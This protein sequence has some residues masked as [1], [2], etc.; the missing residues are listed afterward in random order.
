[1]VV[2]LVYFVYLAAVAI[3][4]PVA[5]VRR[6]CAVGISVLTLASL[7]V[8]GMPHILPLIYLLIGYWLPALLVAHP[9]TALEQYL[10]MVDRGL[11][12]RDGLLSFAQNAP[13]VALE[14]LELAYLFCYAVVPLGFA[15]LL[16]AGFVNEADMF[17]SMVLGASFGCYGMLPWMPTR[18][19]RVLEGPPP[20]ERA[21]VRKLNLYV[22][23]RGSV[24]WNTFPSGHTAASLA[25]AL[26]LG[27][28]VPIGGVVLGFIAVSIAAGSV[29]GR[30]HYA[31]DAIAG[32]L[33][34]VVVFLTAT[35]ARAL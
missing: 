7:V 15:W 11:F 31:A 2:A 24:Q 32:A 28:Y 9:N 19:P 21:L 30:Y 29:V 23:G 18:A 27:M 25:T 35:V 1:M 34:A 33:V 10:L 17:W 16:L 12:G 4:S 5:P 8:I 22:L 3:R 13:R 20:C 6:L 14:Y 26:A